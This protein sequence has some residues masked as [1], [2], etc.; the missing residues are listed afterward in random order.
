[1]DRLRMGLLGCGFWGR[2]HARVYSELASAELVAVCDIDSSKA[3]LVGEKYGSEWMTDPEKLLARPDID[4]V[5]ICT[6]TT[7]H[8]AVAVEAARRGKHTLVEK[9]ICA[10]IEEAR[11]LLD[12]AKRSGARLMPGHIERFN[13]AVGYVK[14]MIER[15]EIGRVILLS[16]KRVTRW[17]ERI[18]DVGVVKD[19]AIHDLDI[20]RFMLGDEVETVY[21]KT[22]SLGHRFEDYAE[23]LL[24]FTRGQTGFVDANWL[25]PRKTRTLTVTGT[26]ATVSLDYITQEVTWENSEKLVKPS[27]RYEEPLALELR[28]FVDSVLQGKEPMVTGLDGLKA[29][30]LCEA[31]LQSGRTGEIV[32]LK[33]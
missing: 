3:R 15:G 2:N 27:L 21:A 16:A 18:G 1:M 30:E 33:A 32:R 8:G 6:P 10:T 20:M 26:D 29:L 17:P 9:P 7:T 28:H 4:A 5:S 12:E 14:A 19:S 22:G 24:H 23:I 13:P 11:A 25:T 31:A